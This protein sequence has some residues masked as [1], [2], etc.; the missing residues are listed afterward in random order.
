[1]LKIKTFQ[2]VSNINECLDEN[3]VDVIVQTFINDYVYEIVTFNTNLC[4]TDIQDTYV[5]TICY[6]DK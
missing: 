5:I 2:F 4:N 6:K 1:M 3:E